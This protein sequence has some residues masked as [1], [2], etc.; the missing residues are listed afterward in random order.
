MFVLENTNPDPFNRSFTF[1]GQLHD[2]AN[3]RTIDGAVFERPPG[4]LYS[5]W[6]G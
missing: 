2:V 3:K 6:S 1:K 5:I 4:Q